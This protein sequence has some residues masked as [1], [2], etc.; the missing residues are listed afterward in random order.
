MKRMI[1]VAVLLLVAIWGLLLRRGLSEQ[2]LLGWNGTAWVPTNGLLLPPVAPFPGQATQAGVVAAGFLQFRHASEVTHAFAH[3]VPEGVVCQ[4]QPV[5]FRP[6]GAFGIAGLPP[7]PA[8]Y[9]TS[10][11]PKGI[12]VTLEQGP[13]SGTFSYI[14]TTPVN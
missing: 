1:F 9:N 2:T 11:T 6:D 4:V 7:P 3:P 13:G 8:N 14:C 10:W 5:A 12:A